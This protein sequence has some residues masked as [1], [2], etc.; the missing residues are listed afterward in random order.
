MLSDELELLAADVIAVLGVSLVTGGIV[1]KLKRLAGDARRL[2][3]QLPGPV[4]IEIIRATPAA[5][6]PSNVTSIEH[7]RLQKRVTKLAQPIGGKD[8]HGH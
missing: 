3:A 2:E 1:R 7:A 8:G 4:A 6:P 5:A